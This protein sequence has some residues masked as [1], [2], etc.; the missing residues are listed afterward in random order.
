[1]KKKSRIRNLGE[2][3][4]L[5]E[6]RHARKRFPSEKKVETRLKNLETL[7]HGLRAMPT[8]WLTSSN[9]LFEIVDKLRVKEEAAHWMLRIMHHFSGQARETLLSVLERSLD[10][11][12]KTVNS[13]IHAEI[14]ARA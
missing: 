14:A 5:R 11:L 10:D 13:E 3:S 7:A 8:I 2:S 1:M 12:E 6:G 4:P 9:H